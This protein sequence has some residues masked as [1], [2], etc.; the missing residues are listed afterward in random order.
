MPL[1]LRKEL[2][3]DPYYK[4]CARASK[5]CQGRITWEHAIIIGKQ[6]QEKWAIIPLCWHHHLGKG[7]NKE[8]NKWI[9]LNRATEEDF[10]KH[11]KTAS[12]LRQQLKYLNKKYGVYRQYNQEADSGSLF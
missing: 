9:A 12:F 5:E 6:L 4:V 3:E 2:A 7:F 8:I 10:Q 1:K 11:P